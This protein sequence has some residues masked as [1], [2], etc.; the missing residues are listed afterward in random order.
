MENQHSKE[1]PRYEGKCSNGR[2]PPEKKLKEEGE[3]GVEKSG[4]RSCRQNS[5][6]LPH[7]IHG[8]APLL[9]ISGENQ[10]RERDMLPEEGASP[11]S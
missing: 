3:K 8:G 7:Q 9:K 10:R 1:L 11:P 6:F 2:S 5:F 4:R